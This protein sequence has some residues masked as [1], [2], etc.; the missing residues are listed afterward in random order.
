MVKRSKSGGRAAWATQ[1]TKA[2]ASF[3][4]EE[5][6]VDTDSPYLYI[7]RFREIGKTFLILTDADVHDRNDAT[8]TNE[9]Y[10]LEIRKSG[11]RPNRRQ[12]AVRIERIVGVSRLTDVVEY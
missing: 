5:V 11:I 10:L 3:A 6:V 1:R 7:G 4:G 2:W 12:V 9:R 8:S